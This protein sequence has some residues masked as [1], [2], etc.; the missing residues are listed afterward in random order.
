M[1]TASTELK[2]G[3]F[4]IAVLAVLA[5]MTFRVGGLDWFEKDGYRVYVYFRNVAGLDENTKVKIAGVDAGLIDKIELEGSVA[6]LTVKMYPDIVLFSDASASV[7]A[8]GLLGDKYLAIE[9]GVKE[10][11]LKDG[12][13]ITNIKETVNIDDM[14]RKLST[15][16][17]SIKRLTDNIN[18]VI[19]TNE[20]KESLKEAIRNIKTIT[21]KLNSAISA[22]DRKLRDTLDN[23]NKLATSMQKV[24]DDNSEPFT[25][26]VSNIRDF[27]DTL[28]TDGPELVENIKDASK[29]LKEISG[30]IERGEGTLGKLVQDEKLYD[31]VSNAAE[32]LG[33]T[34]NKV[35]QFKT[36]LT[37]QGE[38]L[39]K[40]E[41]T[42]GYFYLTLQPRK[43]TY[44][45]LGVIGDPTGQASR[46]TTTKVVNGTTVTVT[47]EEEVIHRN[48]EF[49]ALYGKRY[50]DT[51]LR[52]G[53]IENTFGLGLDQYFFKD[54]LKLTVDAWDFSGEQEAADDVHVKVGA[55][56][57]FY[58]RLFLSAGYDNIFNDNRAGA[59]FGG[60]IRFSDEDIKY[61]L[62][63]ISVSPN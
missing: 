19:G 12:D 56:Y 27:S 36:F 1:Q 62:S 53:L 39:T 41:E 49:T 13:T 3:L 61:L 29:S 40:P 6:K 21:V 15:I 38:Y 58:K 48:I 26:T 9:P 28:K 10:P 32:G 31:S 35:E 44:Y 63:T 5:F 54:R 45:I 20:S 42:K 2:V 24:I 17:D 51:V 18:D 46:T 4:V 25:E 37:F 33:K 43:D 59:Y 30:K 14:A 16:S 11:E 8:T 60:G 23:I 34:I 52:V 55:D 47:E 57:Y 22:N 50:Y 7:N